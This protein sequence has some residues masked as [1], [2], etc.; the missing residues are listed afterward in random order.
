[1]TRRLV[2]L[3]VFALSVTPAA[4]QSLQSPW[5]GAAQVYERKQQFVGALRDLSI[6]LTGRFGD[7]GRRLPALV[8][9]LDTRLR[10]WDE[11]VAA[12]EKALGTGR[13]DADAHTAL[14]TVYLDR[15]RLPEALR[16]FAAAAKL[17]P[18]RADVH[19]FTAM[20]HGLAGRPAEA[21]R[22][23]LRAAALQPDDV[24]TRYELARLAMET[25]APAPAALAAF[26]QAAVKQMGVEVPGE[27]P[28][29][30]PGLV[31]Q[32]A[33]VSPLFPP[34]PYVAAF[35]LLLKGRFEEGIAA[36]RKALPS[37]PLLRPSA[38]DEPQLQASAALRRGE[39]PTALRQLAAAIAADPSRAEAHRLLGIASHL[40]EQLEQSVAAYSTAIR[41]DPTNERARLG[42]ADVLL[43][44]ERF[45]EAEQLLRETVRL[46]PQGVQAQYRLGRL[47]QARGQYD[48]ALAA[49]E[50]VTP[51]T[52]LAGQDPLFEIVA[53]IH[54]N[55]ADFDGAN[56]ALRKQVAVNP[57]NAD[58]HR[59]L[60]DGYVRLGRPA[61]ALTEYLAALL[62]DRRNVLSHVGI[63][64]LQLREGR[65]AEAV[66]AA[67]SVLAL[68]PAQKE[69]RYALATS[70]TRLG[71]TEEARLELAAFEKL[72]M[73]EQAASKR[74]FEL[75]GLNREV[76]VAIDAANYQG[77]ISLLHQVIERQ[78]D[79]A[80]HYVTLGTSL[81]KAGQAQE[82]AQALEAALQRN[83]PD[84]SVHRF[85]AEAYLAAGRPD[86]SRGAAAR[87]REAVDRAKRQ[88]A[89]SYGKL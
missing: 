28:F 61:E 68:D 47:F 51:F 23:L 46:L 44:M 72:Q 21:R 70:L 52:P 55:Q 79:E 38:D 37:D 85:L 24:A 7:E 88:R 86:A 77:A 78:P 17:A 40:D 82:A 20:A 42:L 49:L 75:D 11:A 57:N 34:A 33:G 50:Q 3:L 35:E 48:D 39:V 15:F 53:L 84:P 32:S 5:T 22:A 31:R 89:A 9:A 30:R 25:T 54:A 81:L 65:P 64:Q 66:R 29:T 13:L 83:S 16:A 56:A 60:G 43:D 10:A 14:G 63:A 6:A 18:R 1:M 74:K 69:A 87:Y 19:R 73:A 71:Q 45:G 27:A 12:F 67:R 36:S 26:Q 59:R 62:V 80:S 58:A 8:D 41:L 4:A 2:A 76:A